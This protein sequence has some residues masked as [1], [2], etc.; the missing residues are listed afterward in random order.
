VHD[1]VRRVVRASRLNVDFSTRAS[2]AAPTTALSCARRVAGTILIGL[3]G[4]V[5]GVLIR[6]GLLSHAHGLGTVGADSI[7]SAGALAAPSAAAP[8]TTPGSAA[9][10]AVL[11]AVAVLDIL[12]GVTGGPG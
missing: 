5:G 2:A 7:A 11:A 8:T 1:G 3:A 6:W 10:R 9:W 12:V 4:L